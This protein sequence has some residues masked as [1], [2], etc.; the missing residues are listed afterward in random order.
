MTCHRL[1]ITLPLALAALL[2]GCGRSEPNLTLDDLTSAESLFIQRFVV[3][4]RARAVALVDPRSGNALLD[5]LANIWGDSALTAPQRG[6]PVDPL[7]AAAVHD[8]LKRILLAEQDSLVYAP[9]PRRLAAPL[10]DP[11]AT[12][13]EPA[14]QG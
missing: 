1:R 9:H 14:E 13:S 11:P 6:F 4:E 5:S 7:R 2:G 10:P 12:G 3:L 8:L